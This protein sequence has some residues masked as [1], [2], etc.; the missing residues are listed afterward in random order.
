MSDWI[1]CSERMPDIEQ[2]VIVSDQHGIVEIGYFHR[3]CFVPDSWTG[4]TK[5]THWMPLPAPPEGGE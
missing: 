3:V 2:R 5:P 1:K 4:M